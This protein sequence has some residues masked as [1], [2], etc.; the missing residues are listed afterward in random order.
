[1]AVI[2]R[3]TRA[4]NVS[5]RD[6]QSPSVT[7]RAR[8][9][10]V[11]RR[12][13]P[14]R[15]GRPFALSLG[16][17]NQKHR[18]TFLVWPP[19]QELE[20]SNSLRIQT[21][22][23]LHCPAAMPQVSAL[24]EDEKKNKKKQPPVDERPTVPVP[25]DAM[26][27]NLRT[28][29]GLL[30]RDSDGHVTAAELQFML[31]NLGIQ[32]SDDLISDLIK[33]ASKTGNGLIDENEFMQWVTKIQALQG[34]DVTVSGGD[35]EEEITRDL[36]AAFKVFDRDDNGYITRDELR[37]ALEMIGEPVTDA[38]LN[39]VLALGDIDH[40]GRID[41]EGTQ[42]HIINISNL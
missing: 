30:D 1:M 28:A 35:S 9:V 17:T 4:I 23:V 10:Q 37:A 14:A 3:N 8:S 16:A 32:V 31:R 21:I 36:L 42:Q 7:S 18:I 33:D 6:V 25:S 26:L 29:F 11:A 12:P 40:D 15:H 22:A 2:Y 38:Q 27:N 34:V 19:H 20:G 5:P 41:Y 13:P 24:Q 39:Q